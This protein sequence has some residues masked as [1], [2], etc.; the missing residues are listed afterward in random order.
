MNRTGIGQALKSPRAPL[1]QRGVI[2][3]LPL[4]KGGWEGFNG[5]ILYVTI[6][7]KWTTKRLYSYASL[8]VRC[9]C[10][11]SRLRVGLMIRIFFLVRN[12]LPGLSKIG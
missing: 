8:G 7:T 1:C 2:V 4:V 9:V 12:L 6:F 5:V 10:L 11:D 3:L